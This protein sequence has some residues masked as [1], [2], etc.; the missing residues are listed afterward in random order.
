MNKTGNVGALQIGAAAAL[1]LALALLACAF[2]VPRAYANQQLDAPTVVSDDITRVYV[3]KLDSDTHEYVQGA[4]MAI[5]EKDS[6][7]VVDEWVSGEAPHANEKGLNVGVVYILRE[8][9]APDGYEVAED[10]EFMVNEVEGA[11][12]TVLSGPAELTES[13]RFNL[14]DKAKD[15]E[16]ETVVTETRPT[17]TAGAPSNPSTPSGSNGTT[18]RAVAPKT[19]DET[20]VS[21]VF[22]LVV[23]GLLAIG[24]LEIPKRRM[25]E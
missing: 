24:I 6:G 8:V 2:G 7:T 10:T 18:T 25:K 4:S 14:Y 3:N 16:K 20:P 5:L 13:Y 11:G 22:T 19:G 15:I 21:L 12:I 1:A 23:I 9:A 17:A